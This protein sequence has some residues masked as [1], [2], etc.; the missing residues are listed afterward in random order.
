MMS[1]RLA[2]IR[3]CSAVAHRLPLPVDYTVRGHEG[4][5]Q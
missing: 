1:E 5:W 4:R 3:A 2:M